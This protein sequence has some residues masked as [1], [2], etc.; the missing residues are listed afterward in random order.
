MDTLKTIS[1]TFFI[2]IFLSL[3]DSNQEETSLQSELSNP[4]ETQHTHTQHF[5][6]AF[7]DLPKSS[8]NKNQLLFTNQCITYP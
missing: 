5:G 6:A 8:P 1:S 7:K 2:Q 4:T 3:S